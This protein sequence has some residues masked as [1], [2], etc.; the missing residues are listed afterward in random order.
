LNPNHEK[1]DHKPTAELIKRASAIA[2]PDE[3]RLIKKRPDK[4]LVTQVTEYFNSIGGEVERQG[5]GMVI[6][7]RAGAKS[8]IGH[9]LGRNKAAAFIL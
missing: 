2:D 7:D 3:R 5:M 1:Q 8:S 6:L 4:D 9:K